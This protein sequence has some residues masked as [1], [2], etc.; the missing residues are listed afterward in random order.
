MAGR[1]V[2][3]KRTDVSLSHTPVEP[4]SASQYDP[5]PSVWV[6][7]DAELLE[8]MLDFYPEADDAH[9]GRHNQPRTFL[10]GQFAP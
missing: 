1:Q 2:I 6:G 3:E 10:G 4:V 9:T 8:K 5:L 7:T